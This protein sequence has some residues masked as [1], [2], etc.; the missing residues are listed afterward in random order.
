M[1]QQLGYSRSN[2]GNR[3]SGVRELDGL[4][5]EKYEVQK[6]KEIFKDDFRR[7]EDIESIDDVSDNSA[8]L[9]Y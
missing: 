2:N 5:F 9:Q 7:K 3:S 6:R 1:A 8:F 4:L